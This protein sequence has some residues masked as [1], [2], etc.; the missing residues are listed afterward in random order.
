VDETLQR[1]PG[2][3]IFRHAFVPA[4]VGASVASWIYRGELTRL[5]SL[6]ID[7]ATFVLLL[8]LFCVWLAEQFYPADAQWN[9]H[10]L[11]GGARSWNQFARDLVYVLLITQATALVIDATA[12]A[13]GPRL[14]AWGARTWWPSAA[15]FA[16]RVLLAFLAIELFS[17]WLHRAAHRYRLLWQFHSTHHLVTELNGFKALRTHPIDNLFFY[18]ARNTPLLLLG[19]G[20]DEL[21]AATCLCG[22]LGFVAHA[23]IRVSEGWLGLVVNFP[24]Y[25]LVHHSAAAAEGNS[26]FGCHT[27][28]WDRLFGTFRSSIEEPFALGMEPVGPRSLSQELLWPFF[29]RPQ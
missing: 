4:L 16:L 8:S 17:Y 14:R 6:R 10:P 22:V 19:A 28:L 12:G 23:N 7:F 24:R 2:H 11:S 26:N 1:R 29:R 27:V 5:W 25:H 21:V 20:A 13:L 9:F 18:L 15:P 3:A